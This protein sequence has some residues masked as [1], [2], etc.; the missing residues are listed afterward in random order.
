MFFR[1]RRSFELTA[2][3]MREYHRDIWRV[4][5]GS[6]LE[7]LAIPEMLSTRCCWQATGRVQLGH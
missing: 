5:E 6:R 2:S 7:L 1:T 3:H 4:K